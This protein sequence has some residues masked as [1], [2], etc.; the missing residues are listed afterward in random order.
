MVRG[1]SA[2]GGTRSSVIELAVLGLLAEAPMHGYELRQKLSATLGS[3]R[4]LSYG[5]LYPSLRRLLG[6]GSIVLADDEPAP[7]VAPRAF[8]RSRI[9]YVLTDV[10]RQRLVDLLADAGPESSSDEGFEVHLA[11]FGRTCAEDRVRI[12][13]GRRRRVEERRARLSAALARAA[14]RSDRSDGYTEQLRR[15]GLE[16]ADREIAW[17]TRILAGERP[18]EPR[19]VGFNGSETTIENQSARKSAQRRKNVH[20]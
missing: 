16:A 5:S 7:D 4:L 9:V 18:S 15:L 2:G 8:K 19:P 17:L 20:G 1:Q 3:L 11:F 14:E 12:L 6:S 13:E 10:G